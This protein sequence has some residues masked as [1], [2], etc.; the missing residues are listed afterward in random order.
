MYQIKTYNAIV[1]AGLDRFTDQYQVN[2]TDDADAYLIRSVNLHEQK[3]PQ[4]KVIVRWCGF[5]NVPIDKATENGTAVFTTPG[6]NAN[7]VKELMVAMLIAASRNLFAFA[8]YA[9]HNSGADISK[10]T[11]H[12]KTKFTAKNY[13]QNVSR[14][15]CWSRWLISRQRCQSAGHESH[16][17]RSL[18]V[19]RCRMA[20]LN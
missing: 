2:Q 9:A 20:D 13:W 19:V 16:R 4:F 14:D 17:L 8:D 18:F 5:N 7:A 1:K 12:D 6:G 15:W 11:E 3:F 10:R